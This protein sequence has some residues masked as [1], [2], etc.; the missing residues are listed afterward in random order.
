[1]L[2]SIQNNRSNLLAPNPLQSN[3]SGKG[4]ATE[5]FSNLVGSIT[6]R[7]QQGIT[8]R[9]KSGETSPVQTTA[10]IPAST[11]TATPKTPGPGDVV[12]SPF[13]VLGLPISATLAPTAAEVAANP[14]KYAGTSFDPTR[15]LT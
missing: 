5:E 7:L 8:S 4:T 11:P 12:I 2:T 10:P 9:R 1:M 14:A 13:N 6:R 3:E 15:Q